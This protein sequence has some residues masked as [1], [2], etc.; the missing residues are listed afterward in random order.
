MADSGISDR[1]KAVREATGLTQ[2]RFLPRLNHVAV[3]LGVREYSQ[4]TLSKLESGAQA[5]SFDDVAVFAAV[6]PKRRGRLWLAW[7][8]ERAEQTAEPPLTPEEIAD[9]V[10]KE[11]AASRQ[12]DAEHAARQAA[13]EPGAAKKAAGAGRG[14]SRGR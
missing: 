14:R 1:L 7:G 10:N 9:F 11:L 13:S 6:D 4:S 2:L 12:Y 5:A 8:E 3:A